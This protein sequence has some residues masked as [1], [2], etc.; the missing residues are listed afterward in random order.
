[1]ECVYYDYYYEC[2]EDSAS[3]RNPSGGR[4]SYPEPD[5]FEVWPNPPFIG[6]SESSFFRL[7]NL[8]Q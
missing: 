8:L 1:M 4:R 7:S 5:S 3:S 2:I 6:Y